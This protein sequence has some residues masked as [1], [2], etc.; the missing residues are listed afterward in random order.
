M[1]SFTSLHQFPVKSAFVTEN[2]R[3]TLQVNFFFMIFAYTLSI[4]IMFNIYYMNFKKR[5]VSTY[6]SKMNVKYPQNG[7]E[8]NFRNDND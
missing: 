6:I 8:N 2:N 4:F 7:V 3:K 1:S 5:R